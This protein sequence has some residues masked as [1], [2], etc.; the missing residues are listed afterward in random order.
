MVKHVI[1]FGR[2]QFDKDII[3]VLYV[4]GYAIDHGQIMLAHD[5]NMLPL[6]IL[7]NF[8]GNE[9]WSAKE[10]HHREKAK[11]ELEHIAALM[12]PKKEE[13]QIESKKK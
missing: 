11:E 4:D 12:R 6:S 2:K 5:V 10:P 9:V 3:I 8:D 7:Y 13:I 1:Y